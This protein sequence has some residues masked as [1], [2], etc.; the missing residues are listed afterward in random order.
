TATV[1]VQPA[2]PAQ[3]AIVTEPSGTAQSGVAFVRQP[4][5]QLEDAQGNPV[6]QGGTVI[7]ATI[8]SGPAGATLGA[9]FA[10]TAATGAATFG[11]LTVT[12]PAGTYSLSFSAP[13]LPSV[14]STPITL[15]AGA[16][17][18][19]TL[20]TQP[21]ATA[22]SGGGVAPQP[23]V[24]LRDG[25]GNAVSEAGVAVTAGIGTGGGTPGGPATAAPNG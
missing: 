17:T 15:T 11:A 21:P 4:V 18:Q 2:A 13:G 9:A 12:G 22:Q 3:L 19:L 24:Q 16:A 6:S 10:T 8:A 20:T 14:G 5:I 23:V 25:A 7:T 1:T